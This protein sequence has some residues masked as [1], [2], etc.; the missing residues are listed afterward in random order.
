LEWITEYGIP[1]IQVSDQGS[2]FKNSVIQEINRRLHSQHHFTTAY[3]PIANGS[4]EIIVKDFSTTLQKLRFETNTPTREWKSLLPM[5]QFAL[6]HTPRK[7]KCNLAPVEIMTGIPPSN[8]LD[9]I[10]APFNTKFSAKPITLEELRAHV[11]SLSDSLENMHKAVND[12]VSSK[13]EAQRRRRLTKSHKVNFGLGDFVLVAIPKQKIR[14][15]MQ[16]RWSGPYR[17]I[18]VINDLI[19]KVEKL[20]S[21]KSEIVHAQRMR[22][23]CE[24]DYLSEEFQTTE[25]DTTEKFE[26]S[27]LLDIRSSSSGYEILVRWLGFEKSDDTW[28]PVQQIFEDIPLILHDFLIQKGQEDI[29]KNLILKTD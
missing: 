9:S 8:A 7:D 19:F 24:K 15:K 6:N 20:D 12:E 17:V 28:E 27:E 1:K 29:W 2:H 4:I 26:I 5:V 3:S 18:E 13:R 22:F 25:I 21:T 11:S 10:W 14:N 23:Y 16:I